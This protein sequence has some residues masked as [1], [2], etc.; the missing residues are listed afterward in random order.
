[1]KNYKEI[2][3]DI[4]SMDWSERTN[5]QVALA[6]FRAADG[7]DY[8]EDVFCGLC[9]ITKTV[10]DDMDDS[11]FQLIA[12]AVCDSYFNKGY[13][14]AESIGKIYV[15]D[16]EKLTSEKEKAIINAVWNRIRGFRG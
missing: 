6:V 14:Y 11:N 2:L 5:S 15:N 9:Q 4:N 16:F 10:W 1:M 8:S 3:K 7:E 12:D 13:G